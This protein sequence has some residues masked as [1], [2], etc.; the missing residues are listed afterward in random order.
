MCRAVG[1]ILALAA[2]AWAAPGDRPVAVELKNGKRIFG[3]VVESA[4]FH[5]RF[6]QNGC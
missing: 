1:L 2:V 4:E 6:L 5:I 3:R